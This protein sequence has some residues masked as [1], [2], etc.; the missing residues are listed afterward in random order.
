MST[1][2]RQVEVSG[3]VIENIVYDRLVP[4]LNEVDAKHA[5]LSM[6]T[7]S[8]I[9]MK[10]SIQIEELQHVVMSVSEALVTALV[11]AEGS[12]AN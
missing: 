11:P 8:V 10:P 2:I 9:L 12:A 7:F 5:V 3:E 4:A 1:V 6:L